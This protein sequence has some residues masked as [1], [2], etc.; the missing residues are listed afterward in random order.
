[1][2]LYA[3]P[4]NKTVYNRN[5]LVHLHQAQPTALPAHLPARCAM[6]RKSYSRP[7]CRLWAVNCVGTGESVTQG[8]ANCGDKKY[9]IEIRTIRSHFKDTKGLK[10]LPIM[11]SLYILSSNIGINNE[12]FWKQLSVG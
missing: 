2:P 4:S 1:M 6:L 8:T 5:N 7:S 12:K 10:N 11:P 3:V 9:L